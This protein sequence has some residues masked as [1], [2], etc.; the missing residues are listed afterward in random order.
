MQLHPRDRILIGHSSKSL[1]RREIT[2]PPSQMLRT[3]LCQ[4]KSNEKHGLNGET[5]DL[6]EASI[7]SGF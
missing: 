5:S 6:S 7:S 2:S 1:Q 4:T 3:G